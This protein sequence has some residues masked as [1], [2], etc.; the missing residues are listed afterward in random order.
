M[1]SVAVAAVGHGFETLR[2]GRQ[3]DGRNHG[4]DQVR[5]LTRVKTGS[6]CARLRVADVRPAP[7]GLAD[8]HDVTVE[9]D[10]S[11]K[12]ALTARW[13]TLTFIDPEA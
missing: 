7:L 5:F 11:V 4:F 13:L 1:A 6:A 8:T 3:Q 12:P 9:I 10:G 2:A